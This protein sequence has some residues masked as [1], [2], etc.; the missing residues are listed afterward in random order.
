MYARIRDFISIKM[1]FFQRWK[2]KMTH[3]IKQVRMFRAL[4]YFK[5]Q[6]KH[7]C[8]NKKL[9]LQFLWKKYKAL[10]IFLGIG[11]IKPF[12][13]NLEVLEEND[14][15]IVLNKPAGVLVHP[16]KRNNPDTLL[17]GLLFHI[18]QQEQKNI[19]NTDA[20]SM[21]GPIQR[22]DR[23]TSGIVLFAL[24]SRAKSE[25]GIMMM[26]KS[27]E[28]I[29]TVLV[30]GKIQKTGRVSVPL[31]SVVINDSPQGKQKTRMCVDTENGKESITEYRCIE[32]FQKENVS[33]VSV[34]LITGR[35]HQ[36][37]VHFSYIEHPVIGDIL[38]GNTSINHLFL[39]KY[40]LSR[41]FLHASYF[42]F[43]SP[44]FGEQSF[45]ANLPQELQS[46]VKQLETVSV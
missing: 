28:K 27:C 10:R 22:L 2:I 42:S 17:N 38:Y 6:C 24:S 46:I 34:K 5:I 37:R 16:T 7:I 33:L 39:K 44:T 45:R 26:N 8:T 3:I 18:S 25:L 31:S 21:P 9:F 19:T 1:F 30:Y 32:Y 41:Q 13:M 11:G 4:K 29:Y 40:N 15:Y 43:Q 14:E 20:Q 35:M 36:I 23:D 12:Q